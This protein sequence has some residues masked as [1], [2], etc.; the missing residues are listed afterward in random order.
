MEKKITKKKLKQLEKKERNKKDNEWKEIVKKEFNNK[1]AYCGSDK[2]VHCHHLIPREIKEF[3]H[4]PLN[5]ILLCPL[6]HKFSLDMSPHRNPFYFIVWYCVN[7][8][9]RY[10]QLLS[11]YLTFRDG[12]SKWQANL[13]V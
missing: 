7:F 5:G 10:H 8:R 11:K 2:I 9:G 12:L 3:R 1:C 6:H 13:D 4:E